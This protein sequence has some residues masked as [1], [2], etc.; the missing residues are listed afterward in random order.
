MEEISIEDFIKVDLRVASIESA[1][2]ITEAKKLIK[3]II[4]VGELGKKTVFAG[5]KNSYTPEDLLGRKVI[6]VANLKPREM[7][8]GTSE[9][10]ILAAGSDGEGIYILSADSGVKSGMKVK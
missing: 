9:G 4:D 8:F 7:S 5:I 6:F 1:E 3:L 10:M 2:S